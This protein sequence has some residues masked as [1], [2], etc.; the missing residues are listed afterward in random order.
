[1]KWRYDET[2]HIEINMIPI[3]TFLNHATKIPNDVMTIFWSIDIDCM[4]NGYIFSYIGYFPIQKSWEVT[5]KWSEDMMRLFI[6]RLIWF[7]FW[8]LKS[9]NWRT[10]WCSD[11]ILEQISI[12]WIMEIPFHILDAF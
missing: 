12:V 10:K 2:I 7:I 4:I 5:Y 1:M 6:I 8:L 9:H 11:D 3:L